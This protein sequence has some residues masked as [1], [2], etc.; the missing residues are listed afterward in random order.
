MS[1][2][3][4]LSKCSISQEE[5]DA[6]SL[7]LNSGFLGMGPEVSKFED[8]LSNFLSCNFVSCVN[9]GTA[10]LHLG[11]QALGIKAGDEV[12][13][14][15]VTYVACFQAVKATGAKP[16][17]CD[18]MMSDGALSLEDAEKKL[19]K[20]TKALMYVHYASAFNRRSEVLEF[21]KKNNLRLIED[22][23]HSFGCYYANRK[24]IGQDYDVV[25]FSFDGIKN[26]TCGEG[27]AVVS[28]DRSI[29][30]YIKDARLL[31]VKKD[32]VARANGQR[33][34]DSEVEHQGWRYHMSDINAA[35][36]RVQLKKIE[37]FGLL[38]KSLSACYLSEI[39]ARHVSFLDIDYQRIIPHIF[40]IL[41]SSESKRDELQKV[42]AFNYIET[43]I[44]YKP[45]HMLNFF[46]GKA[47]DIAEKFYKRE[48]SLPLHC[49][50]DQDDIYKITKIVNEVCG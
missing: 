22:A 19:T 41:L 35:I 23:A 10:A 1:K 4:R 42:L 6:V 25:C 37:R 28:S 43:G 7:V 32:S 5:H 11:V 48:L 16:V 34:W 30:E 24:R 13:V 2:K 18:I 27:G 44:H 31:G 8:E 17:A 46:R 39:N 33:T 15:S 14:P 36:G 45:N 40:P 38:R 49:D 50:L 20:N 26:I 12:L 47:C 29:F 3:I 9:S 21:V